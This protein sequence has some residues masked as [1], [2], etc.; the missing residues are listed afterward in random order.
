MKI[1]DLHAH[2]SE[3]EMRGLHTIGANICDLEKMS[4]KYGISKIILMAT[5]FP[6][7]RTGL[8]NS[9]LLE[10]IKDNSLFSIFGSLEAGNYFNEG[11]V[12]LSQLAEEEKIVGIKLYPGYQN[13][14]P[15][16]T[17]MFSLYQLAL[18]HNL[19]VMFH[20]GS[21]HGC[22][23]KDKKGQRILK[24]G[25]EHCQLDDL[26]DFT[27]PNRLRKM[28]RFFPNLK[29]VVSHLSNP[30]F[31]ELRYL[32]NDFGNVFTDISG[33]FV[34]GSPEVTVDYK[35]NVSEEI[36]NFLS[37]VSS[38]TD[39]IAFATDFPVQSY[40]DTFDLLDNLDLST[41]I[42]EKILSKNAKKILNKN[43]R[44]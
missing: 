41:D 42:L 26:K 28:L 13:F 14:D 29:V 5:Y 19:P 25:Y 9:I 23:P 35:K 16:E 11:L 30:Y 24:C 40:R 37:F 18:D 3:K 31:K 7:K 1:I 43:W 12:E 34:S 22:C 10:R 36:F 27:H 15:S 39:R 32:M 4:L 21:A 2:T 8:S 17:K 44:V 38:S 6:F 20:G 33:I